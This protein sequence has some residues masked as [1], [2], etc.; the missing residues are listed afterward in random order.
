MNTE[1][2][3]A[4]TTALADLK[5]VGVRPKPE[6]LSKD[7]KV[8]ATNDVKPTTTAEL[9]SLVQKGFYPTRDGLFS[10]QGQVIVRTDEGAV[11]TLRF[12]EVVFGAGEAVESGK[13]EGKADAKKADSGTT[14]NRFL[15]VTVAFDP[16]LIPE[17]EKPKEDL[18]IP[19]DPF[20]KAPDDPKRIAE[21]KAFKEKTDREQAERDKRLAEAEKKVQTLADRFAGWYYVTPGDSFRLDRARQVRVGEGQVGDP[22]RSRRTSRWRFPWRGL[23]RRRTASRVPRDARRSSLTVRFVAEDAWRVD[24]VAQESVSEDRRHEGRRKS[25]T[26]CVGLSESPG[27]G[28]LR[29]GSLPFD[30][31]LRFA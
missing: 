14:E 20:W 23:P 4:L 31:L 7:L 9:Q 16:K 30:F 3:T 10:N 18:V 11:Y 5:I 19:D 2:L 17:P 25:E 27:A 21:E 22:R 15:M 28:L 12:G 1:K 29:L 6:S 24:W 8:A 26:E 13:D